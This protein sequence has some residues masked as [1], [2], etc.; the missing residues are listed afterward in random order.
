MT[1]IDHLLVSV[2]DLDASMR[3]W[4]D[5]GLPAQAGGAHPGGTFNALVR[6]PQR[7]YVELI[8][9]HDDATTPA[10]RRVLSS[11]GPLSWALGVDDVAAVRQALVDHGRTPGPIQD[12]SRTT[13]GGETLTWQLC[14]V[15]DHAMHEFVP[16][17]IEWTHGM[18]PGPQTGPR[19]TSV[20]LEVPD[21]VGLGQLLQVCGLT[22]SDEAPG[23][24]GLTDGVVDV[25]LRRGTGRLTEASITLPDG[26]LGDVVLDGLV[27]RRG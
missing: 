1:R 10:G 16:F 23:D 5:A 26:P 12:G 4:A 11:P 22:V 6:G 8:S 24:V 17:L 20:T 3:R 7:A 14:D 2:T 25:V 21:P 19:L 15:A 18:E 9:A 27:I 13:L